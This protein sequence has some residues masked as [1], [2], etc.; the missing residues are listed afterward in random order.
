MSNVRVA[1]PSSKFAAALQ[2]HATAHATLLLNCLQAPQL[3]STAAGQYLQQQR[4]Q[5][6]VVH[7]SAELPAAT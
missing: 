5:Q 2:A 7:C 3:R 6:S 4:Q 1:H